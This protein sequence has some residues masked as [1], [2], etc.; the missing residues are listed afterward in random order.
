MQIK[1]TRYH[2]TPVKMAIENSTNNKYWRG[3]GRNRCS[4]T[5]GGNLSWY[6]VPTMENSVEVPQK[7]KN[8][9]TI[10]SSNPTPG[11]I[12]QNSESK[13]TCTPT[14]IAVLFHNSQDMET[15]WMSIN[16]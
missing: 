2:L 9:A 15:T 6:S 12:R 4:Y 13:N 3:C 16:R 1:T 7:T 14:F 11:H 10:R 5:V 8:R